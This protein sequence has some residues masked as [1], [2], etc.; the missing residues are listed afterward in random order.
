[1]FF[2]IVIPV[3]NKGPY[4]ERCVKSVIAQAYADYEIIIVDDGSTDDTLIRLKQFSD[5]RIKIITGDNHGVSYARNIGINESLGDYILFLDADDA[6]EP[7][8][9]SD[10]YHCIEQRD[11]PDIIVGGLVKVSDNRINKISPSIEGQ[12]DSNSFRSHF[13]RE[14]IE[15]DG[16]PGYIANKAVSRYLLVNNKIRF[17]TNLKLAEDLDFWV[18]CYSNAHS[19]VLSKESGYLYY[20][21]VAGSS[22]YCSK[23]DY[24]S[25]LY[26]W[27]KVSDYVNAKNRDIQLFFDY[28]FSSYVISSFNELADIEMKKIRGLLSQI[29]RHKR[30][31]PYHMVSRKHLLS[32]FIQI[33]SAFL[34]YIYL[35]SRKF[36][37]DKRNRSHL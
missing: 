2:S 29:I 25:Q 34:I 33:R 27:S 16:L 7:T 30:M 11:N 24:I 15:H 3:Y 31:T 14:M 9:L 17:D 36:I 37:H 28:K 32:F 18:K 19:I 22:I 21:G 8:L 26:I 10:V 20:V 13:I 23:V 6:F 12:F 35:R 5:G 4:I 1:M